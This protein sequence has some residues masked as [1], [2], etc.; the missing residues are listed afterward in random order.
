M[1]KII[2]TFFICLLIGTSAQAKDGYSSVKDA[3]CQRS[4]DSISNRIID[5]NKKSI[6]YGVNGVDFSF[7]VV[8]IIMSD[9]IVRYWCL[10]ND[11]V[12]DNGIINS[13]SIFLYKKIKMAGARVSEEF[14]SVTFLPPVFSG[15]D[16][17]FVV[18]KDRNREFFFEYGKNIC[19][20][21]P[22]IKFEVFR[23]EWLCIIRKE[24]REISFFPESN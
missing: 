6:V 4:I 13:D 5:C 16:T 7:D 24:L 8:L 10:R 1:K 15:V 19:F 21:K 14:P 23:R 3:F 17:E 20:Y 22:N 11:S 2:L 9:N 12:L 18:Y